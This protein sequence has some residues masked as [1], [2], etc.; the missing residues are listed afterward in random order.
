MRSLALSLLCLA[1]LQSVSHACL[2]E[3]GSGPYAQEHAAILRS[4]LEGDKSLTLSLTPQASSN[5]RDS[6][7]AKQ[8]LKIDCSGCSDAKA[9]A[10]A[11]LLTL[12]GPE[13]GGAVAGREASAVSSV[14]TLPPNMAVAP[15]M[16]VP[17]ESAFVASSLPVNQ[18]GAGG[19]GARVDAYVMRKGARVA[20]STLK[21]MPPEPSAAVALLSSAF[22]GNPLFVK[23]HL[24]PGPVTSCEAPDGAYVLFAPAI[25]Q[26]NCPPTLHPSMMVEGAARCPIIAADAFE[27]AFSLKKRLGVTAMTAAAS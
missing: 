5:S 19:G 8:E 11:T 2:P 20:A 18:P 12:A 14:R 6:A 26:P 21:A 13:L 7:N 27:R 16:P 17:M 23:T 24:K 22:S 10:L 1:A 15:G 4:V 9:R 25:L 3:P